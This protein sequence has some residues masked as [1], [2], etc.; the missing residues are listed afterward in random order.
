M[1]EDNITLDSIIPAGQAQIELM[2]MAHQLVCHRNV[3]SLLSDNTQPFDTIL[4]AFVHL[5]PEAWQHSDITCTRISIGQDTFTSVNFVETKWKISAAINISTNEIGK[6]EVFYLDERPNQ[7]EGPFLRG[8]RILLNTLATEL[9]NFIERRE[10]LQLQVRQ[11]K[12]LELY[13]SLLRHDVKNDLGVILAN[14]DLT[15][16]L[17]INHNSELAEIFNSTEIVCERILNLLNAFSRSSELHNQNLTEIIRKVAQSAQEIH[18]GLTINL[19]ENE[20]S[21]SLFVPK[22]NLLPLVFE[23]LLR[24]AAVHAGK[25]CTVIIELKKLNREV[26]V[27]ISDNGKGIAPEVRDKLFQKGVSTKGGGLG[28][29]LSRQVIETMGGSIDIGLS[30]EG[31]GAVFEINLPLAIITEGVGTND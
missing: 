24:N 5:I 19:I 13:S 16:M 12:E 27:R 22:S 20:E 1:N 29:Y 25:S 26:Q 31:E 14:L 18:T 2:N 8:E 15:K 3:T 21:K 7:F 23:N 11:H 9:G 30:A 4:N 28:L 10:L 6:L 17:T